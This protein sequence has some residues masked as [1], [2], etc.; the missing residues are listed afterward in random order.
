MDYFLDVLTECVTKS[1]YFRIKGRI[2]FYCSIS[3]ECQESCNNIYENYIK[4]IKHMLELIYDVF[5]KK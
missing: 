2:F 4:V 1:H 5:K 3:L